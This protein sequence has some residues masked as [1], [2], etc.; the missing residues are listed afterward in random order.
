MSLLLLTFPFSLHF[1]MIPSMEFVFV[2]LIAAQADI[3]TELCTVTRKSFSYT[4]IVCSVAINLQLN[5]QKVCA[6]IKK[7]KSPKLI[8]HIGNIL[9]TQLTVEFGFAK[10]RY[11]NQNYQLVI[12]YQLS[13]QPS[14]MSY[15]KFHNHNYPLG[16]IF[17]HLKILRLVK[18]QIRS[19]WPD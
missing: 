8:W 15:L 6:K 2:F 19:V 10:P 14:L 18:K 16:H 4:F 3:L 17:I 13:D 12:N 11:F 5:L 7:E 1:L 9:L